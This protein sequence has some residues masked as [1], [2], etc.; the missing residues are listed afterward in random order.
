[1]GV[2]LGDERVDGL[3]GLVHR[4]RFPGSER[5]GQ[6][7]VQ[8]AQRI[9]IHDQRAA[10]HHRPHQWV[11]DHTLGEDGGDVGESFVQRDGDQQLVGRGA[12]GDPQRR[13]DVSGHGVE[14]VQAPLIP[15]RGP[16]GGIRSLEHPGHRRDLA[17]HAAFSTRAHAA[18]APAPDV[19][20]AVS[21]KL[22]NI[23]STL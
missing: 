19:P 8:R 20:A 3:L 21:T 16:V 14:V 1:M 11:G 4:H 10:L 6:R 22:S 9:G 5:L 17:A 15:L 23:L 13:P 18:N 7:N 12:G 2:Y